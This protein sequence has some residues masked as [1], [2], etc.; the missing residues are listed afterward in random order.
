MSVQ[1]IIL[2]FK[3]HFD[4]GFTRLSR[5]ILED[6]EGPMMDD[7]ETTCRAT[8]GMGEQRYVWTMP[9]WPLEWIR[10]RA[11]G[12]RAARIDALVKDGQLTWHALP[13]TSHYDFS[14]VED[15]VH[16]LRYARELSARYGQ[17][18][19]RAA[20][21]TDVPGYGIFLP[22]LLADAG[23][24]FLHLGSNE[25]AS[26]PRVP[27]LFWWE[28]PSGKRV[29]T[30]Y[31][32]GYGS[33]LLPPGD[34]PFETWLALMSTNDN[35][36][37]QSAEIVAQYVE[38]IRRRLPEAR[39]VCGT[40]EDFR[41]ALFAEKLDDLPVVRADLAD[42]WIHG[43][44]SYPRESGAVR[45][46][47]GRL[48]R[49]E[50]ALALRRDEALRVAAEPRL[51]AAWDAV[52][53]YC[54][55]TWGLDVKT[56]LG[57]IPDYD[58]FDA[59]RRDHPACRRMEA[60]WREQS[61][62][63]ETA[64]R[65]CAEVEALLS[66]PAP[67]EA[68]AADF[69]PLAGERVLENDRFRVEY[70]AD[71]GVVRAVIDKPRGRTVL[72]ERDGVGV[73]AYRYDVYSADEL[74]EFLRAYGRRFTDWGVL[75]YGRAGYPECPHVTRRPAFAG[76]EGRGNAVRLRYRPSPDDAYG[77]A[78]EIALTLSLPEGDAPLRVSLEV[79]GKRPTPYVESGALCVPLAA[80][81]PAYYVN[82]TGCVLR[83]E[84]DIADGANHVFY[85]LEHFVGADDGHALLGVVSHDCPLVSLGENGV[86]R[87]RRQYA[88][89]RP[90]LRFNL[91]N[92]MWGTNFP[93]WIEGDMRFEFDVLT[94]ASGDVAALY[95]RA[96]ALAENPD[97]LPDACPFAVEGPARLTRTAPVS[98]GVLLRLHSCAD[99]PGEVV[100]SR[101]GWRF[102]PADL[103][104]Q[105]LGVSRPAALRLTLPPFALQTLLATPE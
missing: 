45:R 53:L 22:E 18:P 40:L 76:A 34:W 11:E 54:E 85:A 43:V 98:G 37:P 8:A 15:A 29:L 65:A 82:K 17:P 32:Q 91:F 13:Y 52:A 84:T 62:R 35:T 90:E 3:T 4:N 12:E 6:Y 67:A 10:D 64:R 92:N 5:E 16:G 41:D 9:A 73:F 88:P 83:P 99:A 69:R 24:D 47:R 44:A 48:V 59:F 14:G 103:F 102:A 39:V 55:H 105:P 20:K 31:S 36:G 38:K 75:D 94:E 87:Y 7:V 56:T 89:H 49:A 104:G 77:D 19:R 78:A 96:S 21:M 1:K 101:P 57:P 66:L 25:F 23:V 72:A 95:R 50:R 97:G 60:S 80:E 63:V 68:P 81:D 26:T 93:Q 71:T 46:L 100:V 61:D 42:T 2:V 74:T 33:G 27:T 79:K 86:F 28:A 70:S 51:R 30:M 58:D